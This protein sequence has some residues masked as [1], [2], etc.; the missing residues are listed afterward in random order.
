MPKV[1]MPIA[2]TLPPR[3]DK[4][5]SRS[6][7]EHSQREGDEKAS[8]N[9]TLVFDY[10]DMTFQHQFTSGQTPRAT[11]F[12][13]TQN[14]HRCPARDH[15]FVLL[16]SSSARRFALARLIYSARTRQRQRD[17]LLSSHSFVS[18]QDISREKKADT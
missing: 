17:E 5:K 14:S 2:P 6:Q 18:S 3:P 11:I 16:A 9:T 4:V 8:I 13:P 15:D 10:M 7:A 12:S 1:P